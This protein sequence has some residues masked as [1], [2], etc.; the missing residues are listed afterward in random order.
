MAK[1]KME[2]IIDYLKTR[3]QQ[4]SPSVRE[5]AN[6]IGMSLVATHHMLTVLK[7]RGYITWEPKLPRAIRLI[8]SA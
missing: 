8:R 4:Y 3:E 1:N 7:E 5:I 6:M 2:E